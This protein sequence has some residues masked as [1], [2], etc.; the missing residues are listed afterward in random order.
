M[1]GCKYVFASFDVELSNLGHVGRGNEVYIVNIYLNFFYVRA[2]WYIIDLC[3]V[4]ALTSL[5]I[6]TLQDHGKN[7]FL[8]VLMYLIRHC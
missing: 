1:L 7:K 3:P 6:A 8:K 2:F 4:G 5:V